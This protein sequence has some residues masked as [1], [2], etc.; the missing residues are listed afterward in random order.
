MQKNESNPNPTAET[1]VAKMTG[2]L[3]G[4][5]LNVSAANLTTTYYT[6]SGDAVSSLE[7]SAALDASGSKLNFLLTI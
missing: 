3:D 6:S 5:D 2:K 4:K 7:T 1:P